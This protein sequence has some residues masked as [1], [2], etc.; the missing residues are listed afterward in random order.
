M[1][2]ARGQRSR[3]H[4]PVPVA[5]V[6][7]HLDVEVRYTHNFS[8]TLTVRYHRYGLGMYCIVVQQSSLY[9][10]VALEK[11]VAIRCDGGESDYRALASPSNVPVTCF[12]YVNRRKRNKEMT[13]SDQE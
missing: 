8:I 7:Y 10:I 11:E 3:K 12:P 5:M 9:I 13:V 1:A 6:F 4:L 2:T